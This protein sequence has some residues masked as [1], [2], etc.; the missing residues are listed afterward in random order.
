MRQKFDFVAIVTARITAV[1]YERWFMQ[2]FQLTVAMA[3]FALVRCIDRHIV[4][5]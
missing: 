3:V 1:V 5:E 2:T 4:E